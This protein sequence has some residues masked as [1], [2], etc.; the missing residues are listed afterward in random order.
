MVRV[1]SGVLDVSWVLREWVGQP[2]TDAEV[3]QVDGGAGDGAVRDRIVLLE[4]VRSECGAVMSTVGLRPDGEFILLVFA[5]TSVVEEGLKELRNS[6]LGYALRGVA[7]Y[8]PSTHPSPPAEK[9]P[10][11]CRRMRSQ[12]LRADRG[13]GCAQDD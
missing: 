8:I 2:I 13:T 4:D 12:R 3:L 9:C 5:E 7:E 1:R 11:S 10:L 6:G